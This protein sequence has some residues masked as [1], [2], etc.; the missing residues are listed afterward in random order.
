MYE[1][2]PES[3]ISAGLLAGFEML[4]LFVEMR[5]SSVMVNKVIGGKG[6]VLLV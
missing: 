4:N 2:C 1:H 5:R 3:L 6:L